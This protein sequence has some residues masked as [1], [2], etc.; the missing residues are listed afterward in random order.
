MPALPSNPFELVS[1]EAKHEDSIV[2]VG[3]VAIGG[4]EPVF[5]GGPCVV[6]SRAQVFECARAIRAAGGHLLRGAVY[7]PS[8]SPDSSQGLGEEGLRLLAEAGREFGLGVV[9]EAIDLDTLMLAETYADCIQIGSQNMQNFSLLR[10]AGRSHRPILLKRS[11]YATLAELLGAAEYI[12]AEGNEH[13]ILCERG[14]RTFES[15]ARNTLDLSIIPAVQAL[16]HLPIIVD[17][18]HGTGVRDHVYPMAM[19]AI[20]AGAAGLVVEVDAGEP[21]RNSRQSHTVDTATLDLLV[22]DCRAVARLRHSHSAALAPER[23]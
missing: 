20:A 3:D 12:L 17:P 1:R 18:S 23:A 13:V 19:A 16:S 21:L 10:Y 6:E 5:C 7:T 9:T 22:R 8:P 11:P 2:L 15:H 14:V 4:R